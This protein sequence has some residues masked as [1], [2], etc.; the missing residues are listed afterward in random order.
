MKIAPTLAALA[1]L[2]IAAAAAPLAGCGRSS[3]SDAPAIPASSDPEG[4]DLVEGAIVP[5]LSVKEPSGGYRLYKIVHVDDYPDPIGFE[6]HMIAYDPKG[7]TFEEAAKIWQKGDV[8]VVFDHVPVRQVDFI[9]R[10]YRVIK[11]EKVTDA[12]KASYLKSRESRK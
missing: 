5:A 7:A 9:K 11:V 1:L 6:Y 10:D 4:K 12:E 8:R 3:T 2:P